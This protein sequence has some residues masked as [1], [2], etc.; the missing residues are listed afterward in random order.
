MLGELPGILDLEAVGE[1]AWRGWTPPGTGRSDIFGGQVASQALRA[2]GFTVPPDRLPNSVHGYFLR[3]GQASAP[4]EFFVE[5]L[6][7]GRTYTAR[8]VD[9][10][11]D[12][13]TIFAMLASFHTEEP[14]REFDHPMPDGVPDPDE[15]PA[16]DDA[17]PWHRSF[18][19][20]RVRVEGPIVRWWGRVPE[21]LPPDA[22]L[23]SCAL[24][25]ASDMRA[26]GAAM[27]AIGYGHLD[28]LES[29]APGHPRGN[30]G[31]LDHAVWFHRAPDVNRWFFCDVTPLTVRDSRGLV[32]GRMFDR[33]GQHLATFTQEM[34]LK[35]PDGPPGAAGGPQTP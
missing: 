3:R 14:S 28:R 12:G 15:L 27:A 21:A 7:S 31:S 25:Y 24:L 23:H 20:R 11:Q 13:K 10:R 26:G 2:A 32:V 6:R 35:G 29:V 5:R 9:V 17:N 18:E 19:V 1:D 8:R 30:F 16:S 4:L 22:L 34:F 33:E